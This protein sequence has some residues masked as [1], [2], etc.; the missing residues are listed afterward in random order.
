MEIGGVSL[1]G[2]WTERQAQAICRVLKRR[3]E[4]LKLE[5]IPVEVTT[6]QDE[7]RRFLIVARCTDCREYARDN[8]AC[9]CSERPPEA[10]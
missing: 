6:L 3:A 9:G 5:L 8:G 10:A 2:Q 1:A 4:A 7:V